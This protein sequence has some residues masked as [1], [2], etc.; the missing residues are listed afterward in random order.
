MRPKILSLL[1]AFLFILAIGYSGLWAAPAVVNVGVIGLT[2]EVPLYLAMEKGYLKELGIEVKLQNFAGS[3]EAFPVLAAGHLDILVGGGITI[4]LFNG[5]ARGLPIIM[6]ASTATLTP[7][8]DPDVVMV[9]PDLKDKIRTVADLKG[10]KIALNLATSPNLYQLAKTLESAGLTLK[11]VEVVTIPFPDMGLAL[12]KKA[13]EAVITVEPFVTFVEAKGQGSKWKYAS[14]YIK[15]WE[16]ASIF[17]NIP[18]AKR[19]PELARNFIVAWLKGVREY[20]EAARGGP[21][22]KEMISVAVKYTRVKDPA[23][24]DKMIWFYINPNGYMGRAS[25]EDQINWYFKNGHITERLALDKVID[26]SYVK[27]ALEKLGV[28]R[29]P[30]RR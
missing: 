27:Q 29:D 7:G 19:N 1:L 13:V 2:D 4:G 24:H 10:R 15:D 22:R 12:E 20:N 14:D 16:I 6:V 3:A 25:V 9:R 30:L 21:N 26:D 18:W 8:H 5:V 23:L 17:Y 28:D 11:D